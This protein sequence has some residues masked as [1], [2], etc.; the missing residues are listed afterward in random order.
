MKNIVR[1]VL[2]LTPLFFAGCASSRMDD[3]LASLRGQKIQTAFYYLGY[4]DYQQ[5]ITGNNVYTWSTFYT[6]TDMVPA[7]TYGIGGFSHH[8]RHGGYGGLYVPETSSYSCV[9]KIIADKSDTIIDSQYQSNGGGCQH[10][11]SALTRAAQDFPPGA[12]VAEQTAPAEDPACREYRK[13]VLLG[14]KSVESYGKACPGA[15]GNWE[16]Q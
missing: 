3:G 2:A 7:A 14:G 4:P 12:P 16:M 1:L 11:G 9:L 8:G 6:T 13:S 10:Y 5:E 15:D